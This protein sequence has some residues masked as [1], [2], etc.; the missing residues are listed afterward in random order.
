[1]I[2]Q[3]SI[4]VLPFINMSNHVD[5]DYFCD[6]VTEE[7]I[8]ALTKIEGL[9][10]TARTSSFAFKNKAIDVRHIGN[11][12]GVATVLEGSIRIFNKRIRITAQLIRTTDGFHIWSQNFDRNL[13]DVFELQDEIS[14]I[15][16]EKIREN[17]GHLD[18]SEHISIIGTK[19]INA[20]KLYLKGRSFQLNWDLD[21]YITAIDYY[22]QSIAVDDTFYD[23]YFALS[24]SYGILSSWG[25]IDKVEGEQQAMYYLEEGLKINPTSYLGYFSKSSI[26]FWNYWN[27]ANGISNL[28]NALNKNPSYAIAYEGIS[29]IYMATGELDKAMLNINLALDISPLSPNHHFTKGNIYFLNKDYKNAITYLD[30]C[31]K[32]DPNFTL[33]IETKLACFMLLNDKL[34]FKNY[35]ASM[36]QLINPKICNFL[37]NLINNKH[38]YFE[39]EL[40]DLEIDID[41]S[42]KSIY[43]WHFYLLI[44]SGNTEK[45]L[46]VF[47][48]KIK[49]KNGQLI[50]FR[51]D[52]FLE[53]LRTHKKYQ[54]L[55]KELFSNYQIAKLEDINSSTK[56]IAKPIHNDK[57]RD[58][59][60]ILK[61][62]I[63]DKKLYKN[64]NFSLKDLSK[65]INLHPNKLSWLL[66]EHLNQNFNEFINQYRLEYFKDE[67]L[68]PSN[69][70]ITLLGIA[71]ESGFNSKTVFNTFFKKETGITP[72]QWVKSQN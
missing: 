28:K 40:N 38:R 48:E 47:E 20:Y 61:S 25:C 31:L 65:A 63:Q 53:P 21:D 14:L 69:S 9:K 72:R 68:K 3:K 15:I 45:A 4:A 55:E 54:L 66:N 19:N 39:S 57:I 44:H 60:K 29:E 17:F 59:I 67:V 26:I 32:I 70:H 71:Y 62:T 58:Y 5:N 7:I 8:N 1:M 13:E 2:N 35:I 42:F 64:S 56:S 43:P 27:Y 10:V 41:T 11:E 18:I 6:G 24:R 30:E 12:L 33:A 36:P 52:P 46:D 16:A 51:L 22:K 49:L 34:N 23:A 50:N 37:F